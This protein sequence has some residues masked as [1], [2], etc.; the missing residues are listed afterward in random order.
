MEGLAG[1]SVRCHY[2]V[3]RFRCLYGF[4]FVCYNW[5]VAISTICSRDVSLAIERNRL[6]FP[7]ILVR[8]L[9]CPKGTDMA[10]HAANTMEAVPRFKA[11]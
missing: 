4:M 1:L 5:L 10:M 7:A 3:F 8:T 2:I 11:V 9:F 6:T